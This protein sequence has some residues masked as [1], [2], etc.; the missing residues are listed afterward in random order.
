MIKLILISFPD[1]MISYINFL[2][3]W[4][5]LG[6]IWVPL[7]I[8]W[9]LQKVHK[10]GKI[11]QKNNINREDDCDNNI[12]WY[13]RWYPMVPKIT[14]SW[15]MKSYN[16]ETTSES[17]LSLLKRLLWTFSNGR[18]QGKNLDF[19]KSWKYEVRFHEDVKKSLRVIWI[20]LKVRLK[21]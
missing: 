3:F 14:K 12:W 8:T 13:P 7:C 15:Y 4:V 9:S 19:L 2:W 10:M 6:T 20:R 18:F 5:P 21:A 1:C 16:L 17:I 11:F